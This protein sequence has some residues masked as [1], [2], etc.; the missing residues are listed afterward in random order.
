MTYLKIL[1]RIPNKVA[2]ALSG[3]VDSM[4]CLDFILKGKRDVLA[5]HFNHNTESS[6]LYEDFVKSEM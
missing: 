6:N 3:G 2:I 5:L 4:V 1:N